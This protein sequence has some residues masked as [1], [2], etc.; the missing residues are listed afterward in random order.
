MAIVTLRTGRSAP[1]AAA[2]LCLALLAGC[3]GHRPATPEGVKEWQWS[4][5]VIVDSFLIVPAGVTLKIEPGTV[6]SFPYDDRN[7]DGYGDN[8]IHVKGTIK[9][10]GEE[11][12]PISFVSAEKDPRPGDWAG[13]LIDNSKGSVFD[14]TVVSHA[15]HAFH[16]HFSEGSISR[17]RIEKNIEGTRLGDSRFEISFNVI[18]SNESKGLNFRKCANHIH[19]NLITNNGTGIFLFE[20]DTESVIEKNDIFGNEGYNLRLGDFYLGGFAMK[21]NWWGSA[22]EVVIREGIFEGDDGDDG[23]GGSRRVKIAPAPAPNTGPG[24]E[25]K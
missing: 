12:T 13:F 4:G 16:T 9:A 17:S 20:K 8:G 24:A 7:G 11:G 19:H 18:S 1:I 21:G 22:D 6:V 5:K 25:G 23:G 3:A 2:L 15:R 14:R 10:E